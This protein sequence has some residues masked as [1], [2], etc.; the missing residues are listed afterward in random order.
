MA[1]PSST[2]IRQLA[3]ASTKRLNHNLGSTTQQ[4]SVAKQPRETENNSQKATSQPGMFVGVIKHGVRIRKLRSGTK[5]LP[6]EQL[7]C[8]PSTTNGPP[9]SSPSRYRGSLSVCVDSIASPQSTEHEAIIS[10]GSRSVGAALESTAPE[11]LWGLEELERM[12]E[13]A[14]E[15]TKLVKTKIISTGGHISSHCRYFAVYRNVRVGSK[16][17]HLLNQKMKRVPSGAKSFSTSALVSSL[18]KI[19]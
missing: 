12:E 13:E 17:M 19:S 9:P 1:R 18:I 2:V 4:D 11:L 10:T 7:P 15:V 5:L 6:G 14:K 8:K 16:K 3:T